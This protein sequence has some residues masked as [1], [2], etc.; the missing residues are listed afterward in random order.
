[1]APR[2]GLFGRIG[3]ALEMGELHYRS[4]AMLLAFRVVN[5]F[6]VMIYQQMGMMR[7]IFSRFLGVQNGPLNYSR[8]FVYFFFNMMVFRDSDSSE[9][10]MSTG[11]I[12][13]KTLNSGTLA[14]I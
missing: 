1:M 3:R 13:K 6:W 11:L 7:K 12:L 8:I 9:R 5:Y 14:T 4:H 10:V 2:S